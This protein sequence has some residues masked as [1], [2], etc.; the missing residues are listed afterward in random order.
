MG[1]LSKLN[2]SF[3]NMTVL[4]GFNRLLPARARRFVACGALSLGAML[5]APLGAQALDFDW[6][7]SSNP[8]GITRGTIKGLVEGYNSGGCGDCRSR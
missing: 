2:Q 4:F 5:L 1:F 3:L 8:G 7:F 6:Y